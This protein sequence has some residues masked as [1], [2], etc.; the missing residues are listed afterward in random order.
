MPKFWV[1]TFYNVI[2][3]LSETLNKRAEQFRDNGIYMT[4]V[5]SILAKGHIANLSSLAAANRFVRS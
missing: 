1:G 2:S 4:S 3:D 5:E